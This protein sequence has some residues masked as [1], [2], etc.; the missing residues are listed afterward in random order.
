[1]LSDEISNFELTLGASSSFDDKYYRSLIESTID[2]MRI[3]QA[4][5]IDTIISDANDAIARICDKNYTPGD[6]AK[7]SKE[8]KVP[9][10]L[11]EG[12]EDHLKVVKSGVRTFFDSHC[13]QIKNQINDNMKATIAQAENLK[14]DFTPRLRE[15]GEKYMA[16]LES[17]L[18]NK[19]EA[20]LQLQ[21]VVSSVKKIK[22]LFN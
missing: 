2:D 10:I 21:L 3:Y 4:I 15:E 22:N 9:G 5:D 8:S 1:M 20:E 18:Q 6:S 14:N 19:K 7:D 12:F 11:K 16:D 17:K 13:G